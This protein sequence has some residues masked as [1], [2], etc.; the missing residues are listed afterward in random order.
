MSLVIKRQM[1]TEKLKESSPRSWNRQIRNLKVIIIL[2]YV[3]ENKF[4][5]RK[6]IEKLS[7]ETKLLK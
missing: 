4:K 5:I 6:H 2:N 1:R 3:K 7:K